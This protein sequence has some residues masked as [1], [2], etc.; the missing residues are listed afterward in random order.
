MPPGRMRHDAMRGLFGGWALSDADAG[1]AAIEKVPE[2][3]LRDAAIQGFNGFAISRNPN[4]AIDLA[5]RISVASTRDKELIT[6][7]RYWIRTDRKAAEAAIR[8]HTGIPDP[9]KAEIFK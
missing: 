4:L 8:A 1:A 5:S 3:T 2:G 7:G 9:V 6:R